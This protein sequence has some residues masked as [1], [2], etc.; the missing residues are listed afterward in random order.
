MTKR[1]LLLVPVCAGLVMASLVVL[2]RKAHAPP[3]PTS[4]QGDVA[5]P[6]RCTSLGS[7]SVTTAI[8]LSRYAPDGPSQIVAGGDVLCVYGDPAEPAEG[9]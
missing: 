1:L 2:P 5:G 3:F 8:W 6:W 7:D 9:E 4:I